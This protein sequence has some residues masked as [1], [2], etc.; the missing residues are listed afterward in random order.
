MPRCTV[1]CRQALCGKLG[2]CNHTVFLIHCVNTPRGSR[3]SGSV[4]QAGS[5]TRVYSPYSS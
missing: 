5:T 3:G 1:C 4:S 2:A